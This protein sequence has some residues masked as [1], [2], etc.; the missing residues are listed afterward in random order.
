VRA[1]F[2]AAHEERPLGRAHLLRATQ[3][4]YREL[5]KLSTSSRME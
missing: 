4:E 2:L 5:G 3:L 1:A